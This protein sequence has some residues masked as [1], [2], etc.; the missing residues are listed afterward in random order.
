MKVE[1]S[2]LSAERMLIRNGV[3][4]KVNNTADT[5]GHTHGTKSLLVNTE[6]NNHRVQFS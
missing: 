5:S 3:D 1:D 2:C 4:I 6:A